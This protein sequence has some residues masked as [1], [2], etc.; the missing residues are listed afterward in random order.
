MKRIAGALVLLATLQASSILISSNAGWWLATRA[1]PSSGFWQNV[2]AGAGGAAGGWAG[3]KAG[4]MLGSWG[5]P[6]GMI[7]GA[8]LGAG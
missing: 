6:V 3:A 8:G 5:G 1:A 4:A 7:I 2:G